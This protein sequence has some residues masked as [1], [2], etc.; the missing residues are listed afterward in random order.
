[1]FLVAHASSSSASRLGWSV[2]GCSVGFKDLPSIA[3]WMAAVHNTI[4]VQLSFTF[5]WQTYVAGDKLASFEN[6][7]ICS[8][9]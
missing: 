7:S 1:M 5:D 8:N 6:I 4:A 9:D 2:N 3:S